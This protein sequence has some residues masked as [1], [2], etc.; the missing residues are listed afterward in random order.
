MN[1]SKPLTATAALA[2]FG[3]GAAVLQPLSEEQLSEV[4]S[5]AVAIFADLNVKIGSLVYTDTNPGNGGALTASDISATG[6]LAL[7]I[8]LLSS[9]NVIPE[10]IDVLGG[11][12]SAAAITVLGS[13]AGLSGVSGTAFSSGYYDGSDV[14]KIDFPQLGIAN[15][16]GQ[17]LDVSIGSIK[18]GN[19][20]ASFGSLSL[21]DV[22]VQ[23]TKL[24]IWAH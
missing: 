5:Q 7:T 19:G 6:P 15:G 10:F 12:T 9:A 3:L 24:Y 23:G 16:S 11:A 18:M 20:A 22:N 13:Q 17:L 8:D 14:V 21:N 4:T 1:F 2:C